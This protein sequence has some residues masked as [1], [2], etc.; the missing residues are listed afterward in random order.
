MVV[1]F[2]SR[3]ISNLETIIGVKIWMFCASFD[4]SMC[5]FDSHW[6][7]DLMRLGDSKEVDG[8]MMQCSFNLGEGTLVSFWF[9]R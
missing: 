9:S 3:A 6:W 2:N 7:K 8:F 4:G 1:A 5:R